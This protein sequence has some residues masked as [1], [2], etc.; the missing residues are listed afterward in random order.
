[1]NWFSQKW[2]VCCM[3]SSIPSTFNR[4]IWW[5]EDEDHQR[6]LRTTIL[7]RPQAVRVGF[8]H[9]KE[10]SQGRGGNCFNRPHRIVSRTI[11][12]TSIPLLP[13]LPSSPKLANG[14]VAAQLALARPRR[15]RNQIPEYSSHNCIF[16]GAKLVVGMILY[17]NNSHHQFEMGNSMNLT[18]RRGRGRLNLSK[19][20]STNHSALALARP[21]RLRN[22]IPEYSSP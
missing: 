9:L 1:M 4:R 11:W 6:S 22:Q 7:H 15:L 2:I 3:P 10:L 18:S 16:N 13:G 14:D 20:D 5:L 8:L 17:I 12:V 21:R 19:S